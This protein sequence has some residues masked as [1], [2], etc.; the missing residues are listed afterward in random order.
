VDFA[1]CFTFPFS[2]FP[3]HCIPGKELLY[4]KS[5]TISQ[6]FLFISLAR[7]AALE[8]NASFP[9]QNWGYRPLNRNSIF[10]FAPLSVVFKLHICV[11][12]LPPDPP[13]FPFF[14]GKTTTFLKGPTA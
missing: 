4:I 2:T 10:T 6:F 1:D 5:W 13:P 7:S 8:R 12:D 14:D 9:I 11:L 3:L